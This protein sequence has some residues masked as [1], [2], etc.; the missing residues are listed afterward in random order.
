MFE[1]ADGTTWPELTPQ[2]L[3]VDR[4]TIESYFHGMDEIALVLESSRRAHLHQLQPA[5][6]ATANLIDQHVKGKFKRPDTAPMWETWNKLDAMRYDG[7][8]EGLDELVQRVRSAF[9]D[10]LPNLGYNTEER[11]VQQLV[12][13]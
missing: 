1:R 9:M 4:T 2:Q 7:T 13:L 10:V 6:S 11:M 3:L 5:T 12:L 8:E